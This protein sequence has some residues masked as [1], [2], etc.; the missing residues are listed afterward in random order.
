MPG[1]ARRRISASADRGAP[2]RPYDAVVLL[3]AARIAV[4]GAALVAGCGEEEAQMA[5]TCV[6]DPAVIE[7]A[8]SAAPQAVV[9]PDGTT[10]SACVSSAST[11]AELQEFGVIATRVAERLERRAGNDPEAA[12]QLGYLVGASR[13]GAASTNG[14]N[15]ELIRRLERSAALDGAPEPV[16]DALGRGVRAGEELG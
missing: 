7:R 8:L 14:V 15:V 6:E 16:Q 9:L 1:S 13:R 11:A 12:V 4:V 5:P 2:G 10:L 3:R